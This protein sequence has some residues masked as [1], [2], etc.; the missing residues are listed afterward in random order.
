MGRSKERQV[1]T[2]AYVH[3]R[4]KLIGH[5]GLSM[6]RRRI[7]MDRFKTPLLPILDPIPIPYKFFRFLARGDFTSHSTRLPG[8]T[9]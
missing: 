4:D 9:T 5:L 1:I 2:A 7:L 3:P 6:L 8:S